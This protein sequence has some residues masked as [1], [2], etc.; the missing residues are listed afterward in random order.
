[1][2]KQEFYVKNVICAYASYQELIRETASQVTI[3]SN[4]PPRSNVH[5]KI[6]LIT[7]TPE[8]WIEVAKQYEKPESFHIVWVP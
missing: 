1:M 8:K 6:Q 7:T 3:P 5:S 4:V 2:D